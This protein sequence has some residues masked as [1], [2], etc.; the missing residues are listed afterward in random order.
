METVKELGVHI[1]SDLNW[2]VQVN[3]T[4]KKANRI[5]NAILHVFRYHNIDLHVC[6]CHLFKTYLRLL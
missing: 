1:T 5:T 4:L 2:S 6:I 3:A